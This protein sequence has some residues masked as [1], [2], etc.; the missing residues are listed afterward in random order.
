MPRPSLSSCVIAAEPYS[1]ERAAQSAWLARL[2]PL[3]FVPGRELAR[4]AR[5]HH[6]FGVGVAPATRVT[7]G[8]DQHVLAERRQML[9]AERTA[10]RRRLAILRRSDAPPARALAI[11]HRL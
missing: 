10:I 3:P 6:A 7:L 4:P 1:L 5:A 9:T 2:G 8:H 11:G